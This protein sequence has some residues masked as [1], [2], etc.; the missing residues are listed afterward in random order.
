MNYR[1]AVEGRRNWVKS[2]GRLDQ[3]VKVEL[4]FLVLSFPF[5]DE[6]TEYFYVRL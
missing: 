6:V 4:T 1:V 5:N 3:G 2:M